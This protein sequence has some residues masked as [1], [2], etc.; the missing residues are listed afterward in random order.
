[1]EW[2][3][4]YL[5]LCLLP[6][7]VASSMSA[8]WLRIGAKSFIN[9]LQKAQNARIC[10]YWLKAWGDKCHISAIFCMQATSVLD[11]KCRNCKCRNL[12]SHPGK[13][14]T[15]TFYTHKSSVMSQK[16]MQPREGRSNFCPHFRYFRE[17][18]GGLLTKHFCYVTHKSTVNVTW[19]SR[20]TILD[21]ADV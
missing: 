20:E 21:S 17:K 10:T 16:P 5:K 1:M 13:I 2:E 8:E 4:K 14:P 9:Y 15:N 19:R 11:V 18:H 7:W 6:V 12:R 3:C